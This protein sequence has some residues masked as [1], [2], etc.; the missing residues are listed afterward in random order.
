MATAKQKDL[1]AR[2]AQRTAT[3]EQLLAKKP[4]TEVVTIVLDDEVAAAYEEAASHLEAARR[5]G[6]TPEQVT[7]LEKELR[8]LR[9]SVDEA[10][11]RMVFRSIGAKAYDALVDAH[12]PTDEDH[13]E[14]RS[15]LGTTARAPYHG[16]SFAPALIGA[17]LAEPVLS[18]D[19]V[20]QIWDT[21]NREERTQLFNAALSVNSRARKVSDLGKG[22]G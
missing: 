6:H 1:E 3:R 19:E 22:S 11:V 21:W 13:E 17:S 4:R 16:D 12:P 5:N 14:I 18:A 9:A 15:V 7:A 10:T 2:S 20:Q 8:K